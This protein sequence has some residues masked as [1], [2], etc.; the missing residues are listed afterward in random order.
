MSGRSAETQCHVLQAACIPLALA[1]RDICGSAITGTLLQEPQRISCPPS[2]FMRSCLHGMLLA[3]VPGMIIYISVITQATSL[4]STMQAPALLMHIL[5][6]H[7]VREDCS[8]CAAAA[9]AA[10]VQEQAP[11]RHLCARA[12]AHAGAGGAGEAA[13]RT[14]LSCSAMS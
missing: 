11:G 6:G 13:A 7:R 10:A 8:L 2:V 14:A 3:P 12:H 1:G 4:Q 9:G 5:P